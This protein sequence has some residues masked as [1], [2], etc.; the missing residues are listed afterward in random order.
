MKK[1]FILLFTVLILSFASGS[2]DSAQLV[3][4][5]PERNMVKGDRSLP[6]EYKADIFENYLWVTPPLYGKEV[7]F[8]NGRLNVPF[9]GG[10]LKF[11]RL[12]D[13][14]ITM[15][16]NGKIV[17]ATASVTKE[18]HYYN[19][20]ILKW[21]T[22]MRQRQVPKTE[23]VTERVAVTK[24]RWVTERVP[25]QKTRTVYDP[26][27]KSHRT[28]TYTD[29]E[30]R[31]RCETY[32]DYEDRRVTKTTWEWQTVPEQVLDIPQYTAYKFPLQNDNQIM[33][34]TIADDK[35]RHYMFQHMG[36]CI[37]G[38][39][40]P[41][42]FG[43]DIPILLVLLDGDQDGF[44]DGPGDYIMYNTWNPY[45][46]NQKYQQIMNYQ[47][48]RWLRLQ[49]LAEE[50]FITVKAD[51][52]SKQL[53][54]INANTLFLGDSSRG[55]ITITNLPKDG[56]LFINGRQ[57]KYNKKGE[58]KTKI[59][60]G[61]YRAVISRKGYF[62]Q[63]IHFLV[64]KTHPTFITAY[65]EQPRSASLTLINHGFRTWKF[66]VIDNSGKEWTVYNNNVLAIPGGNYRII[67]SGGGNYFYKEAAVQEG[68]DWV[69]D[70]T[71]DTLMNSSNG[72][73]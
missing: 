39:K 3:V 27:T 42:I 68:E 69:Y 72:N 30:T 16:E 67:V 9:A 6:F 22:I 1:R 55:T 56:K 64:D 18:D 48:N 29:W 11:S 32:T 47:D 49:S 28:E 36:Y 40:V 26:V 23:W 12:D 59:E 61:R 50:S 14:S 2:M 58:F 25:V 52:A 37:A 46:R 71:A 57:Y 15:D 33:L 21:K 31:S 43:K 45:D 34:Y 53:S 51:P 38:D 13:G 70:F 44:F 66:T 5:M 41:G 60:Y 73:E 20:D 7:F 4:R 19:L 24:T 17:S 8:D 54:L 65:T 62:D 10:V 35:G 63:T